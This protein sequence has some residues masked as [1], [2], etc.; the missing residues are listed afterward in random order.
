M[1]V[2]PQDVYAGRNN[3]VEQLRVPPQSIEAE[4]AVL[5]GLM[6]KSEALVLVADWLAVGDFYRRDHQLIYRAIAELAEKNTPFDAVTLG[7][8]FESMGQSEQV[9]G[10]AYLVELAST[11]P[12]AAN[13]VAYAEIVRDKAV[14]RQLIEVGTEAVN[15]GFSPDGRDT[16][17]LIAESNRAV[18]ALSGNPR[19]GGVK[20]MKDVGTRWFAEMQRRYENQ[21]GLLGLPTPWGKFNSLTAGLKPG[22]LIVVAGRPSMGKSAFAVNIATANALSSKRVMFFNLEMTDISI[23]NRAIASVM[24]VPLQWLRFP[25]DEGDYWPRVTEGMRLMISSA[26]LIDDTPAL[27]RE[28]IIARAKREHMRQPL[29]MVIIDHLH[30]MP[31]DGKTRETVEIGHITRDLKALAKDLNIPVVLLSQLNRG[32]ETRTGSKRPVMADLRESGN[33]EQDADLIVFLYRDDYYA[34]KE[35]RASEFPGFVEIIIGKQRE[36]ET[37]R[38]WARDRLAYGCIDDYDGEPPIPQ[39]PQSTK[40]QRPHPNWNAVPG[41]TSS[42]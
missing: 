28:Q 9:A 22:D 5:G 16:R 35:D 11:T 10:G 12:S 14:L 27:R 29:D 32:L 37:G 6:L 36:G 39:R 7:E 15:N 17:E 38:V 31:L 2:R 40:G 21:S 8:W 23:F 24:T 26:L 18:A 1:S 20:G 41:V 42:S 3:N 34:E 25:Q 4:Q 30:L 33:I 19:A 13:I